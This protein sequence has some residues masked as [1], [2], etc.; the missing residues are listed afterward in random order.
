LKQM[1]RLIDPSDRPCAES[2]AGRPVPAE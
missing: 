1:L 2:T